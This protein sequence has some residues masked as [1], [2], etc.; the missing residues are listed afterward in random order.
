P[1]AVPDASVGGRD[2]APSGPLMA[3][4]ASGGVGVTT[5]G[6]G[7][8]GAS[9]RPEVVAAPSASAEGAAADLSARRDGLATAG[10]PSPLVVLS[11]VLL[12]AAVVLIGLRLIGRRLA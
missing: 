5:E 12:A 1:A 11:V 8:K 7:S 4:G 10:P 9:G 3:P 6:G 2:Q